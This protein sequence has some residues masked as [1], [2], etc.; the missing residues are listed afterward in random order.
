MVYEM[1]YEE[2]EREAHLK[3]GHY[4]YY[5]WFCLDVERPAV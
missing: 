5:I 4:L 3:H 2:V 1:L